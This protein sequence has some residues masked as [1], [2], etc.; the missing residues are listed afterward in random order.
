MTRL[1]PPT[2]SVVVISISRP[3]LLKQCIS[4]LSLQSGFDQM[5]IHIISK[6]EGRDLAS[7]LSQSPNIQWHQVSVAHTVPKMRTEGILNAKADLIAMLED[8]CMVGPKWYQ[9]IVEAHQAPYPAVGGAIDPGSYS[10]GIDWGIYYCEYSR[11]LSPFSGV[12]PALPG[13]NV[14]YKRNALDLESISNGLYEVFLHEKWQKSGVELFAADGMAVYNN[15][16]WRAKSCVSTPFHHGRAYAAQR[17]GTGLTPKKF[18]YGVLA[19]M[20]PL[21]KSTRTIRDVVSR[22]Q[23]ELPVLKALPWIVLFQSCWSVGEITGYLLGPGH[24]IEKW[25]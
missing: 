9:S 24:S 23:P 12:V 5:D 10:R 6:N 25:R 2:L 15:N 1:S 4:A 20:L 17:F 14:S 13:N 19:I 3:D 18:L 11:F 7:C 16:S 22:K 8:D 21:L